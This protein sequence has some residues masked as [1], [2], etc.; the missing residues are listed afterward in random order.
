METAYVGIDVQCSRGCP[1]VV[2]TE[3]LSPHESGWLNLPTELPPI[4]ARLRERFAR[5]G[6][7]IDA[8]RRPLPSPREHYW[9]GR[10]WRSRGPTDRGHGRHCEV[11]IKALGLANPQWTPTLDSSPAWMQVGFELF[12][13]L[14]G[15]V[16]TYEVFPSAAYAQ[17][18]ESAD[19]L[20]SISLKGFVHGPKDMLDAYVAAYTVQQYLAGRGAAVGGGD[21]LG[22]IIL[23]R[24]VSFQPSDVFR[25]PGK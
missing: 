8:P 23:P 3:D 19:A 12:G 9:K 20:V 13:S 2:V 17:L 6:V 24:P 5:V 10:A 7:G 1:Y 25:W 15:Q 18:A 22:A 14:S 4:V 16:D 21:G 11:V